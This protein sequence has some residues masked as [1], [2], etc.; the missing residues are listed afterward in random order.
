[1]FIFKATYVFEKIVDITPEFMKRKR[2][3]GVI[4]DLDNTLTTHNNPIVPQSSL[5]WIN[6]MKA[7][8]IKLMIV[9]N[10]KAPRV[11][12]FAEQLGIDFVSEGKKPLT[13]GYNKAI[14]KMGLEKANVAAVGDQIFTDIMGSNLCGIRSFFVFPIEPETSLPFRLKRAVEKPL[15]PK[16]FTEE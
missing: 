5:E 7:A 3:K 2:I 8:G 9:S 6:S 1:M 15:L 16:K 14:K 11:T 12:P 10:N 4:L 13:F